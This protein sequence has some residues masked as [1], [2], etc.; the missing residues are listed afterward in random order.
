MLVAVAAACL[1]GAASRG[2]VPEFESKYS[3][4]EAPLL[5]AGISDAEVVI[6]AINAY[7][8]NAAD[9]SRVISAYGEFRLDLGEYHLKSREAVL[10]FSRQSWE[11]KPYHAFEVF[12]WQDAE[13][14]QP[15]GTVESGPALLVTLSSFGEIRLDAAGHAA[16]SD[17]ASPL[18]ER[19]ALVRRT[20]AEPGSAPAAAASQPVRLAAG[21]ARVLQATRP[22]RRIDYSGRELSSEMV[23]GR[24]VVIA[25]G[26]VRVSQSEGTSGAALELQADAAVLWLSE[27]ATSESTGLPGLDAPRGRRASADRA[28]T[29]APGDGSAEH[30]PTLTGAERTP[31]QQAREFVSAVYLEGD[32]VLTRGTRMI[33]ATRLYYD[34]EAERALS[35][36]VVMR[37]FTPDGR[38]PIY[39]RAAEV[40]QLSTSEYMAR[41]AKLTTSEF[42]TPHIALGSTSAYL[43][44]RTPRNDRGEVIGIQAGTYKA[45]NATTEIEGVPVTYWPVASGDFSEDTLSLRE[46]R[47]GYASKLGAVFETRWYLF[48]LLGLQKPPGFDA[49][50]KLDYFTKRGPSTGVDVDYIRENYYGLIR[51]TYLYDTGED[52]YL[53]P[54]RGGE[55]DTEQRGRILARHRQF[56]PSA[57]GWEL[58]LETSYISDDQYLEA[59]DRREFENGKDQETVA[60]L[61]KRAATW[62]FSS[63]FNW[64]I[65][66]FVS[67]TEHFPDL[68][69]TQIGEKPIDWATYYG[70][71]RLSLMRYKYDDRRIFDGTDERADNTGKTDVVT[72]GETRQE[73]SFVPPALG[74]VKLTPYLV[75]RAGAWDDSPRDDGQQRIYG[76]AGVRGNMYLQRV[77]DDIESDLLDLHRLRHIIKPDAAVWAAGGNLDSPRLT[78]F[79]PGVETIDDFSGATL[80]LRQRWQTQRGGAG[81]WRTVD[82]ITWDI[83]AGFFDNARHGWRRDRTRGDVIYARPEDSISANFLTTNFNY[84]ISE[85]T[86]IVY[87]GTYDWSR[88][89]AGSSYLSLNVE[90]DPRL[91]YF[92]GW[93]YIHDTDSNLAVFGANYRLNEK[94]SV[95]FREAYDLELSRNYTTDLA[96]VRR[97]PRWY[98]AIAFDFDNVSDEIGVTFSAWPEGAP[99]VGVGSKRYTGL[100]DSIGL[101]P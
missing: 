96:L 53:G 15:G 92:F 60:Y 73:L 16:Q 35:L 44:D 9:G 43:T 62:Q 51:S 3:P 4:D 14:L 86:S 48:N 45:Y 93:R 24:R 80:G 69:F 61:V 81:R 25:I 36:D 22:P 40:R 59:F 64:R 63:L 74:P 52:K 67:L 20:L 89:N 100:G 66:D 10:W 88:G 13:V 55:P 71:S 58:S 12:L 19:A 31:R 78:P 79:D 1:A 57:P 23:D 11:N 39:V 56:F 7:T 8:W 76:A 101:L 65:M 54:G 42:Y 70:D 85:S 37:A 32:V 2:A 26:D 49:T 29:S 90:R 34:L 17:E 98:T 41:R 84:R 68:R 94:Y 50:L 28:G 99:R 77:F 21:R 30:E 47:V 95:S 38:V 27:Q 91:A 87:E 46:A 82:W 5:P 83:E 75:G 33:R 97:W 72:R 6:R 18:Y